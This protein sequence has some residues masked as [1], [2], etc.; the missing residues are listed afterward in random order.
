MA[1]KK[2]E[3]RNEKLGFR[4]PAEWEPHSATWLAWPHNKTDW[5]G[6]FA[7]IPWVYAQIVRHLSRHERV[8]LIVQ[9]AKA[10]L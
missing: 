4:M 2:L 8:Y 10:H 5:P 7:P 1:H 9:N 3:T 6:K